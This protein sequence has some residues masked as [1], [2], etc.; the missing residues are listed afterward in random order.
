MYSA[1]N[2]IILLAAVTLLAGYSPARRAS[3]ISPMVAY[4]AVE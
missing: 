2:A 4:A 3:R 1:A